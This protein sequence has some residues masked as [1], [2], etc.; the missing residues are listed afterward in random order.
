MI[1]QGLKLTDAD[2]DQRYT[3]TFIE[4][5]DKIQQK[6]ILVYVRGFVGGNLVTNTE[7]YPYKSIEIVRDCPDFGAVLYQGDVHHLLRLPIRQWSRGFVSRVLSD[8]CRNQ[9]ARLFSDGVNYERAKAAFYPTYHRLIDGLAEIKSSNLRS[10]AFN[11]NYW[12]SGTKNRI[13]LWRNR[14]PIGIV[15]K[16]KILYWDKT[17]HFKQEIKDTFKGELK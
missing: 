1:V 2:L 10:F 15:F 11:K 16:D 3:G 17:V 6:E 12:F 4:I 5:F 14:T 8:F 13:Y 9:D 7:T